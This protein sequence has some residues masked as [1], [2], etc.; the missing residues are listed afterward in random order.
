M[1][2]SDCLFATRLRKNSVCTAKPIC[3][4]GSDR[5]IHESLAPVLIDQREALQNQFE[6]MTD[7]PFPY[8]EF[9]ETRNELIK[10]VNGF[11]N[12]NDKRFLISFEMAEPD[13]ERFGYSY[14]DKYP[15][16]QWKL[17]NLSRL[18]MIN[19][20]KLKNETDKLKELFTI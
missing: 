10:S 7:I 4:L 16:V 1:M 17:V 2:Y 6:G 19:P 18:K 5:P 8:E 3:L 20:D 13:W 9:E 14:F 12:D 11:L 15:S